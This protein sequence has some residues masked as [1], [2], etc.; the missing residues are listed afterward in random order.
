MKNNYFFFNKI[1]MSKSIDEEKKKNASQI[2][3]LKSTEKYKFIS[4]RLIYFIEYELI[5]IF[6]DILNV[7]KIDFVTSIMA[8]VKNYLNKEY[9]NK[10]IDEDLFKYLIK[11]SQEK[12]E[13]KYDTHLQN[14]S[15]AW[16]NFQFLL[17][18]KNQENEINKNYLKNFLYHCSFEPEY[19]IHNCDKDGKILGKFI[20]VI[21]KSNNKN[22]VKYVICDN[23][24]KSYFIEHFHTY[25]E[26]CKVKYYSCEI[27]EEKKELIPATLKNPHCDPVVNEKLYCPLCKKILYFN[28]KTDQIK[29][30][31]CRFISSSK[32]VEWK[33]N[34]CSK[35]FKSDIIIYNKS[36][37]NYIKKVINYGLLLKK[38]AHPV[39]LFCCKNIDVKTASFYHKKECKG[40]IYFAEFHKKLIII[41]EKCKAVNNFGKFIWT[42]PGCSLRFKDMKWQENEPKLR[43]EIFNKKDIKI[44]TEFNIDDYF[45][46]NRNILRNLESNEIAETI[47]KKTK[48]KNKSNL[49][50]IL[51]KR[52]NFT[53]ENI[54]TTTTN[55]IVPK[56]NKENKEAST[57]SDSKNN[58]NINLDSYTDNQISELIK[59][60]RNL[61]PLSKDKNIYP[62]S[63]NQKEDK[64]ADLS[65]DR[66][67]LKKRY[68]FEKLVRRQFVSANNLVLNNLHTEGNQSEKILN[69]L[70][71]D[72]QKDNNNNGSSSNS[73][74]SNI[75]L[76]FVRQL[77]MSQSN[78][79]LKRI[80]LSNRIMNMNKIDDINT[81]T[82]L[83]N[84]YSKTNSNRELLTEQKPV[85]K[86]SMKNYQTNYK[87]LSTDILKKNENK[88][89]N[90]LKESEPLD[91]NKIKT[92]NNP[93]VYKIDVKKYIFKSSDNKQPENKIISNKPQENKHTNIKIDNYISNIN[94]QESAITN[95]KPVENNI[96]NIKLQDIININNK[97]K[98][99]KVYNY[100]PLE[101]KVYNYKPLENTNNYKSQDN[102]IYNYKNQDIKLNNNKPQENRI[103]IHKKYENRVSNNNYL[104]NDNILNNNNYK[105]LDSKDIINNLK[106]ISDREIKTNNN[107][108]DDNKNNKDIIN[109]CLI[110]NVGLRKEYKDSYFKNNDN[111]LVVS[112]EI[113]NNENK[114]SS[115]YNFKNYIHNRN[116]KN[117]NKPISNYNYINNINNI[118]KNSINNNDNKLISSYNYISNINTINKRNNNNNDNKPIS[119]YN[120]IS[121][122]NKNNS[123][124]NN[125]NNPISSYNYINNINTI[126][127]N[128]NDNKPI[129]KYNYISSINKNSSNNNENK[130]SSNYHFKYYI[131][132]NNN[133][134][135]KP[136][137]NYNINNENK[138]TSNYNINNYL[139]SNNNENKPISNYN[140]NNYL[141]SNNNKN[142]N[143]KNDNN[144]NEN[145][146]ISN[147]NINN[148]LNNNNINNNKNNNNYKIY[149]SAYSSISMRNIKNNP[150]QKA[151]EEKAIYDNSTLNR[152]DI[153]INKNEP[154]KEEEEE[155]P[156]DDLIKISSIDKMETIP[157]DPSIIKNP[158]IYNNIQQRIKHLLYRGRLPLFN[159]DNYTIKKNLGEGT[160]G[161]I[162]Q[163]TNNKTK[164]NYAMKKLIAS[165]IAELEMFL[166][167]FKICYENPHPYILNIYGICI[168]CFDSTTFVLYVLMSLAEKD[169]EMEISDRIKTKKYFSEKELIAMIKKLVSALYFLQKERN[170]AHRD[171][172]PENILIFK[173]D[174]VK[175]ADFGEAKI[176]N[177]N[178]K[179]TIRGTEFYMSPL[180][181]AGN[182][183][184]KYN[185]QHNPFKSDVFSLGYCFIYA[186]SLDY[187]MINEIRK[188]S[189]QSKLRQILTKYCPK[190]YSSRYIEL[191]LKMI[192]NDENQRIDFIGLQNLLQYY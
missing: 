7:P 152:K 133:N 67:N 55:N 116:N 20:K 85:E 119:N 120:Y 121:S 1:K 141:A 147:L 182:L 191:L 61:A 125:D 23:C 130:P 70:N 18:T 89:E 101:N 28:I 103:S 105:N 129:S 57:E 95:I 88:N 83:S 189:D 192:V 167:E 27:N 163:V 94:T 96:I 4:P 143:N 87:D 114:P 144:K 81:E 146:P 135:N 171:V 185:I 124:N 170:V 5:D 151:I 93:N 33:C 25:C 9:I 188:I 15:T 66:K 148:Y 99:N 169:L 149:E 52:T 84:G 187:E 98:D 31:N 21:D 14:L 32:N 86:M 60:K 44:N 155:E 30:S 177:N 47:H 112:K 150:N 48:S 97:P 109:H 104:Q 159:V 71:K 140:L 17:K 102:K 42:C 74:A 172:K 123:N 80:P 73:N 164:K 34:I 181:Y 10:T 78:V 162:Y 180:L 186:T 115:N 158:L 156:P 131:H 136:T 142:E 176:N 8:N 178:K 145:K 117:E 2:E 110:S 68:I 29:C 41:C 22:L 13:K 64:D 65:S 16:D 77:P 118:N 106:R 179:K 6:K 58:F 3:L 79:D 184:S 53:D 36:E 12:L 126:N 50:D 82:I 26:K 76:K 134:E 183:E 72:E 90:S 75:K 153:N 39:K 35:D 91:N 38:N 37:V 161:V 49:Y 190:I 62:N 92:N 175:L 111:N 51:K 69:V 113:K 139:T 54:T 45:P 137:S 160:N 154:K 173:N 56:Y 46:E 59:V 168:R 107:I 166:K 165:S 63:K 100:K 108:L 138:P 40:V 157:L 127:K 132:R 43:K 128:N 11:Y 122:I 24:R 19:A 174:I